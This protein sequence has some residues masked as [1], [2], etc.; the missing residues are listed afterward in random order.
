MADVPKFVESYKSIDPVLYDEVQRVTNMAMEP[1]A[2]D[3]KTK[4]LITLALDSFK[5]AADGVRV[6]ARQARAVGASDQEIAEAIRITYY[7][8]G[9]DSLKTGLSAFE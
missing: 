1:G 9:F 8:A 6:L 4:L 3:V 2:L 7:V 5:G